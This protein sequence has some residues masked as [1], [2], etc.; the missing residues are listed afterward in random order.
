M[1]PYIVLLLVLYCFFAKAQKEKP[2]PCYF[3][4]D[5]GTVNTETSY[6]AVELSDGSIYVAGVQTSG[7]FGNDDVALLKYDACG[8]V[9]WIKYYGDT[10]SNDAFYINKTADERLVITGQTATPDNNSDAFLYL[11][12]TS[13]VVLWQKLYGDSVDQMSKYVEQ[14]ADKGFVFCGYTS[15]A[16]G[17]NDTYVVKTDS[18]GNQQ[19]QL[20]VGGPSVEYADMVHEL[21][22]GNFLFTGDTKSYGN[23]ATD[24]EITKCDKNGN[25]IW[26]K[27]YGDHLN[28]GCQGIYLLNNGNYLSYGETEVPNSV[29]F[30]F[31]IEMIDTAGNSISRHAFGGTAADALFSLTELPGLELMCTGY[32]RSFNGLQAYDIVLFKT[33]TAGNMKWLKNIYNPGIDIGYKIIPS[34]YGDYIITGLYAANNGNYFLTRTDT[35]A[36]TN[37]A[38]PAIPAKNDISVFPNPASNELILSENT[39]KNITFFNANGQKIKEFAPNANPAKISISDLPN[40][41]YLLQITQNDGQKLVKKL[42]V[43]H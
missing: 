31:F 9:L 6:G 36:N 22:D 19:W 24:V 12:D 32:S 40:G 35:M 25:I 17:S 29:A 13:G 43:D 11:L 42:C 41:F 3:L 8:N 16:F 14:T 1:R 4:K 10:L 15:D 33:D 23:G 39:A 5:T 37:V 28:N 30:D 20:V 2:L 18:A 7:P 38:V 21:P 34:L 27:Y 26:D